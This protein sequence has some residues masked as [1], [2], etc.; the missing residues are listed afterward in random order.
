MTKTTTLILEVDDQGAVQSVEGLDQGL[1]DAA[2]SAKKLEDNVED[3]GDA[4]D[5]TEGR[6]KLLGGAINVLGGTAELAVGALATIGVPEES[7]ERVQSLTLGVIA[8]ADGAK[9]TFEG[10]KELGEGVK[11]YGGIQKITTGITKAFGVALKVAT[12]PVGLIIA[13]ITALGVILFALKDKVEIVS[14]AFTFFGNLINRVG[15]ALGL[16]KTETEKFRDAQAELSKEL[17]FEL[18]LLQAQGASIDE[19]VKKERELLQAKKNATKEGTEER[20]AAEQAL[21]LFEAKV[22]RDKQKTID[23]AEQERLKKQKEAAEKRRAQREEDAKKEAE[24]LKRAQDIITETRLALLD[25]EAREVAEREAKYQE[26]LAALIA[27]G[28]TDFTELNQLYQDDL[29]EIND[30]YR[31][32]ELD[33][34]AAQTEKIKAEQQKRIDDLNEFDAFVAVTQEQQRQLRLDALTQ[35]YLQIREQAIANGLDVTELDEAFQAK[36][37]EIAKEGVDERT[38]LEKFFASETAE[39]ISAS[40]GTAAKLISTF[41]E[42]IDESTKEGFEKSKKYKIAETIT[43]TIE[44]AFAAY[45]SLVGVPFVGPVLGA[46]AAAAAIAAGTKAVNDIRSS[47]FDGGSVP[48]SPV[49]SSPSAGGGASIPNVGGLLS[50]GTGTGTTTSAPTPTITNQG[51]ARAYVLVNDVNSAQEASRSINRRRSLTG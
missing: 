3:A 23:A 28:F 7:V 43:S 45:K 30:K 18:K 22:A 39:A 38:K 10:F 9:R 16:G 19:L 11:A 32:A 36:R 25:E 13:G 26:E 24:E 8:L 6:I 47:T 21:A 40:L 14:K 51:P 48:S 12:G 44:A 20:I 27:A 33:A 34:E 29:A 35:E 31:E 50:T 37:N 2:K 49:S 42:N 4:I 5:K 41:S 15:K 17:D 1:Q 46:A